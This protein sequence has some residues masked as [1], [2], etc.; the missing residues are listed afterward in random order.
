MLNSI[1]SIL[2]Q[3]NNKV[4]HTGTGFL[5]GVNGLFITVGHVFREKAIN[6][7]I[8]MNKFRA[9]FNNET[10]RIVRIKSVQYKSL[11]IWE[12]RSSEYIDIAIGVLASDNSAYLMLDRKRPKLT[13]ELIACAYINTK[14]INDY[15][16]NFDHLLELDKIILH[17]EKMLVLYPDALISD[18]EQNYLI[19]RQVVDKKHFFNNCIT[20]AGKLK[21][22]ASGCPVIDNRGLV[23]GVLI[24]SPK[25]VT[26]TN[27]LLSKWSSK[28]IQFDTYHRYNAYE[29]LHRK[30]SL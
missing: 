22:G 9:F 10:Q 12:Q 23:K 3:S 5:I 16:I 19:D 20:L 28:R 11:N 15:G 6:G 7:F 17:N 13:Q 4:I 29:Y 18:I 30:Q 14:P 25:S 21:K 2:Y 24:G 27:I 1:F 26:E 8:D